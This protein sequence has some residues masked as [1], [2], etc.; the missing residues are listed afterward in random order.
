MLLLRGFKSWY[1]HYFVDRDIKLIRLLTIHE[2]MSLR[3]VK[4]FQEYVKTWAA[5]GHKHLTC[6]LFIMGRLSDIYCLPSDSFCSR[7]NI[8]ASFCCL[9][10]NSPLPQK[11]TLNNAIIES[12]IWKRWYTKHCWNTTKE[13]LSFDFRSLR[14]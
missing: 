14:S 9:S 10:A 12:I 1:K 2:N 7:D 13:N 3:G 11:S 5:D 4:W 6:S 8:C